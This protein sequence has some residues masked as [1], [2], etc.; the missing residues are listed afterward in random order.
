MTLAYNFYFVLLLG[1]NLL[2]IPAAIALIVWAAV[3]NTAPVTATAAPVAALL[4]LYA[5][6]LRLHTPRVLV[7]SG[8]FPSF[9]RGD[10]TP[11]TEAELIAAVEKAF[12][13]HG[14]PPSIVGSGWGFFLKRYGPPAPRIFLH[15]F[16]GRNPDAPDRWRSGT[17]ITAV[18]DALLK[19]RPVALTFPS[20]PT[21]DYI[22]LGAWFSFGN[23]GNGGDENRGSSKCL[24]YAR[25][26]DMRTS[27]DTRKIEDLEYTEI[28]RR[29]DGEDGHDPANYCILDVSFKNLAPNNPLKKMAV[30][31]DSPE[32]AAKWLNPGAVLR[33]CFQGAARDYA[34]A[35]RWEHA[36]GKIIDHPHFGSR[37]CMYLQIDIFSV[38]FGW[39]EPVEK[40]VGVLSHRNANR[41]MPIVGPIAT[42]GVILTGHRN[43][44]L[45]FLMGK[46]LDPTTMYELITELI[47]IHKQIGGRSEIRYGKTNAQTPVFLDC[48]FNRNASP[49]FKMLRT[50]FGI[51]TAALHPGKF[52]NLS[53][54]PIVPVSLASVYGMTSLV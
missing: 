10:A 29:F 12:K 41:W 39:H 11:T 45:I 15:N 51:K 6:L 54:A 13:Q 20:H 18:A 35:M 1:I 2:A 27:G 23:H 50:K 46:S 28:R 25:V 33:V 49:L 37:L 24:D 9:C 31:I 8:A 53:I 36:P 43:F 42:L 38:V 40:F 52:S 30:K 5:V 34:L 44:E 14:R 3:V 47:Q 22:S 26:F 17:T 7:R 48:A 21:Q 4:L 16:K 32:M 19:E